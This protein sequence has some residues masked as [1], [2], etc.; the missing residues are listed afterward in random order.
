M[1]PGTPTSAGGV[2]SRTVTVK[3][4]W[5]TLPWLSAAVQRT[6]VVPSP[7]TEPDGGRHVT[8]TVP[9]RSSL[10]VTVKLGTAPA[11]PA[12]STVRSP[13]PVTTGANASRFSRATPGS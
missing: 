6:G 1:A 3:P 12:A 13:G 11:G 4:A 10:A 8:G 5:P 2:V 7:N 9:S